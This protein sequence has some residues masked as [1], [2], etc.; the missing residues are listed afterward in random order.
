MK[1][2]VLGVL[3]LISAVLSSCGESSNEK[4]V[5]IKEVVIG[6]QVWMSEN[7][8][9]DRFRNGDPIPHVRSN[10]EWSRAGRNRQPAWCYYNNDEAIGAKYG[11]LYN[12][13]AVN[14][15]RGLAPK[16]YHIPNNEEWMTLIDY[17]GSDSTIYFC[18]CSWCRIALVEFF[19]G[20]SKAKHNPSVSGN[21]SLLKWEKHRDGRISSV[22]GKDADSA[23]I[24][25]KSRWGWKE[26]GNGTNVSGFSAY[27]CGYRISQGE[28]YSIGRRGNWWSSSRDSSEFTNFLSIYF[29]P[30]IPA[31]GY[32][33][34]RDGISVRCLKD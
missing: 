32:G 19:R 21:V 10:Q 15:P 18:N 7:L 25:I 24:R 12:W 31:L 27:P 1:K 3:F 23:G 30:N 22:N 33:S 8:N 2:Q 16:G 11:K 28:F 9:V 13:Y 4:Q 5:S 6:N 17:L 34:M 20:N 14:D 26:K 29:W